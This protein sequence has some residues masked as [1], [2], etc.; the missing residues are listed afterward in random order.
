MCRRLPS[1]AGH[2]AAVGVRNCEISIKFAGKTRRGVVAQTDGWR[3]RRRSRRWY[4]HCIGKL[5]ARP[6]PSQLPAAAAT[7][8]GRVSRLHGNRIVTL[9]IS[10]PLPPRWL[11]VLDRLIYLLVTPPALFP[12]CFCLLLLLP[13]TRPRYPYPPPFSCP[14]HHHHHHPLDVYCTIELLLQQHPVRRD[15]WNTPLELAVD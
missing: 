3:G 6:P 2:P 5:T 11:A 9:L 8:F 1:S 15:A 12:P 14:L 4:E 10:P 7:I 13:C